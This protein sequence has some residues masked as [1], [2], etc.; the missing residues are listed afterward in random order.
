MGTL[1]NQ[2][3]RMERLD[4]SRIISI[5]E[6]VKTIAKELDISFK[7]ALNLYMAVAKIDD[8]DTKDEQLAGLGEL[9]KELSTDISDITAAIH[10]N[11]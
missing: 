6:T 9:L 11:S 7:D 4:E 3:P 10:E 5:G 8:Y 2:L 1:I